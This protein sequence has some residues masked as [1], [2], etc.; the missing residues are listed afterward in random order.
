MVVTVTGGDPEAKCP[1]QSP[2]P[3]ASDT[4]S[5]NWGSGRKAPRAVWAV[6]ALACSQANPGDR[7]RGTACARAL[8]RELVA[9]GQGG[10]EPSKER[11]EKQEGA[12]AHRLWGVLPL[13]DVG[14]DRCLVLFPPEF[15]SLGPHPASLP[16]PRADLYCTLEVDSFGYFVS[17]AKTR[18]FRDTTEPKWDEVSGGG[19]RPP[20]VPELLTHPAHPTPWWLGMAT[21]VGWAS[22][23]PL[24]PQP[25]TSCLFGF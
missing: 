18:V 10:A 6:M 14:R 5:R 15:P 8:R 2:T 21:P 9:G 17:K 22:S 20:R 7:D 12:R 4:I 1:P 25:S 16:V 3:N 24:T 11:A 19:W 23:V 13:G